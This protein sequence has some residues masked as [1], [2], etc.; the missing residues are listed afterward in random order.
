MEDIRKVAQYSYLRHR[1]VQLFV[2]VIVFFRNLESEWLQGSDWTLDLP[3]EGAQLPS[4]ITGGDGK[5][6]PSQH[7]C[8]LGLSLPIFMGIYHP[9]NQECNFYFIN[10]FL[11]LQFNV[12]PYVPP[13]KSS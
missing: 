8:S 13:Y 7:P 3:V 4:R 11:F 1:N 2:K 5:Q 12:S 9:A 10:L 6:R